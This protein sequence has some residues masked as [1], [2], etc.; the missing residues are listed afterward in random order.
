VQDQTAYYQAGVNNVSPSGVVALG[1]VGVSA[2]A[3]T[4]APDVVGSL[5][6]D[7]AWGFFKASVA[8]HD[9]HVAYYGPT[10]LFGH[11]DDKWGFA[12]QLA[13]SIK[14]IPTGP[15]DVINVQ[16]VYTNGA[17]RYNIQDLAGGSGATARYSGTG[18]AGAYQ[19]VGFG[20]APDS[21]YAG[22]LGGGGTQQKLISTWGMR[23]AYTH[24]W[25][26]YWNTSIYGAWA[27]V[28]YGG[29]AF[30]LVCA[31]PG[32]G[33]VVDGVVIGAGSFRG[34]MGA[35][36]GQLVC[37]PDYNVAQAGIITRWTPVKNLTFSADL[38]W[39]HLDQKMV[40]TIV[41]PSA[42]IGK[43]ALVYELK[44]QDNVLLLLRAQ[45]NW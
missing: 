24:N 11:P 41:A 44:D 25:D 23:G 8:A 29:D 9:N 6:V 15:G 22:A 4:I 27:T 2:Y 34:A 32:A 31:T 16:G 37:N 21:V 14:N 13:L 12:G 7:Q 18:L 10:E 26:P 30:T 1:G 35:A 17:T 20:F 45:R 42:T 3:N 19:S 40:G 43:P 36:N 28:H 5:T 38:T 33:S 39:Q